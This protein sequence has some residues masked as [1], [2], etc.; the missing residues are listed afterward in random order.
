MFVLSNKQT[1]TG[2]VTFLK[3]YLT[4]LPVIQ[5]DWI[6]IIIAINNFFIPLSVIILNR[7][8]S[9]YSNIFC[10]VIHSRNME[11]NL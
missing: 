7:C 3:H 8:H 11:I 10:L 1:K 9:S 5:I 6:T 2:F 4:N